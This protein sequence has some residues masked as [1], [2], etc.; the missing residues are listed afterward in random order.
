MRACKVMLSTKTDGV[1][2]EIVRDGEF[3]IFPR[4]ANIIY[5]EDHALVKMS[6]FGEKSEIVREGDYTLSLSL[7][8]GKT[9]KGSIGIGGSAG[10]ILTETQSIEYKIAEDFVVALL[11]YDLIIGEERQSTEVRLLAK[12]N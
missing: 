8:S 5:R 2:N 3:E 11:V 1:D 7:E 9:T 12:A 4:A 6:L 10:D